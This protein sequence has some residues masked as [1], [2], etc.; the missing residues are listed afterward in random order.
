VLV[1]RDERAA[2]QINLRDHLALA[3]DD[4]SRDHLGYLV[5]RDFIPAVQAHPELIHM[6]VCLSVRYSGVSARFDTWR[7][8]NCRAN[9]KLAQSIPFDR[10]I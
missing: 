9:Y 5:E 7:S 4:L 3:G 2:F 10:L 8:R 1:H 6:F